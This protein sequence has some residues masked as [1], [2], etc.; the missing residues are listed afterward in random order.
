MPKQNDTE[1]LDPTIFELGN[2]L[3]DDSVSS[4][5]FTLDKITLKR[6]YINKSLKLIDSWGFNLFDNKEVPWKEVYIR[7]IKIECGSLSKGPE[8]KNIYLEID[9]VLKYDDIVNLPY[10]KS[11][12]LMTQLIKIGKLFPG[13]Q[14]SHFQYKYV[15]ANMRKDLGGNRIEICSFLKYNWSEGYYYIFN[16]TDNIQAH[17][18]LKQLT[19]HAE[20]VELLELI[21][22]AADPEG[23]LI[24]DV[25][26]TR[27]ATLDAPHKPN[28]YR[29]FSYE[30]FK[31]KIEKLLYLVPLKKQHVYETEMEVLKKQT[32]A[33]VVK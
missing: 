14:Y 9:D 12:N 22:D 8:I 30:K 20:Q 26:A 27:N 11:N 32:G 25:L 13:S 7:N 33:K 5:T 4:R 31:E 1:K 29:P 6:T 18:R 3:G 19:S 23:T 15:V 24:I 21:L 16:V 28:I 2:F 10:E 17:K